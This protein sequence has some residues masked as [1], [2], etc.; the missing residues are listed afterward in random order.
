MVLAS[1]LAV[2]LALLRRNVI[3]LPI[4]ELIVIGLPFVPA[5][6]ALP[7]MPL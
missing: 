6:H 4:S 2:V 5:M 7:F 3:A 1:P